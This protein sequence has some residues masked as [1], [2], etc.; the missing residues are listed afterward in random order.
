MRSRL[1]LG[2]S[3]LALLTAA[4]LGYGTPVAAQ[5]YNW[6]GFYAGLHAGVA[7]GDGNLSSSATCPPITATTQGYFCSSNNLPSLP[8][9]AAVGATGT[10]SASSSAFNGGAQLGYNIQSG[11]FVFGVEG[12]I[13]TFGLKVNGAG[14]SKYP[15]NSFPVSTANTFTVTTSTE[16]D[17]LGT[18][19][20]RLG[21]ATSNLLIYVT[22]GLAFSDIKVSNSFS[23]N[24]AGG[25]FAGAT[26]ASSA[27]K[28]TTGWAL[29]GGVEMALSRNWTLKGEY[30]YVDL[31]SVTTNA[32]IT[33]PGFV[34]YT[35]GLSTRADLNAQIAR[36]GVNYKF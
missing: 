25:G 10:G 31:G 13:G 16:A 24:R 11:A 17:W 3:Q 36:V 29:G 32:L 5:S 6:S 23:D 15:V 4:A 1:Y 9:A 34:G 27:S 12:D 28:L 22:G 18:V 21:Y 30:L 2:C 7:W 35:N 33:H 14:S 20:G 8:N 19:R 26:G